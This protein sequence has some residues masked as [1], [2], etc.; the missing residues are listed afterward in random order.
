MGKVAS[1]HSATCTRTIRTWGSN[2]IYQSFLE[3]I[4]IYKE[5]YIYEHKYIK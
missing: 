4:Q 2:I 3:K 5:V 1:F